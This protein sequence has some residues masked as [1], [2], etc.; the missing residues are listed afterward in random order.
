MK[1]TILG[2]LVGV[3]MFAGAAIA[4]AQTSEDSTTE[5]TTTTTTEDTTSTGGRFGHRGEVLQGVLDDLVADGT[6]TQA[7]A[8]AVTAGL[9]AAKAERFAAREEMRAAMEEAWSDGALTEEELSVLPDGGS[10]LTDPDGPLAEYW[11][12]GQITQEELD[13][14]RANGDLGFGRGG[15][16]GHGFG[17][18]GDG[19]NAPEAENT[20][21]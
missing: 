21:A 10:R 15:R 6:L 20:G 4:V 2:A 14:A 8:D 12:D 17:P 5:S 19:P 3:M 9:E 13:E 11:E 7:Q 1:K 16:H 18:G